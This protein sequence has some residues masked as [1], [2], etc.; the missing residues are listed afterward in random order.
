MWKNIP[1]SSILSYSFEANR[2]HAGDCRMLSL[3]K[4][5]L[6]IL[7]PASY[8]LY[9]RYP[10]FKFSFTSPQPAPAP[11]E[12]DPKKPLK[13]IMQA[14][15]DDLVPPKDDPYTTEELKQYDGSD[16]SKPIYVA[17]KGALYFMLF[18]LYNRSQLLIVTSI[19]RYYL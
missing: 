8:L 11:A 5:V 6:I 19:S 4:Y 12:T 13:S 3:V 16:A 14:P 18:V 9:R 1:K 2:D 7:I 15:R 17:I 10:S